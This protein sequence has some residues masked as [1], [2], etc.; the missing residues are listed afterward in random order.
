MTKLFGVDIA[1]ELNAAMGSGLLP[2]TLRKVTAGRRDPAD[3][4]GGSRPRKGDSPARGLIRDYTQAERAQ[5]EVAAADRRIMLL[6]A[7]LPAGIVP[8]P[9]DRITIEGATYRIVD[10]GVRRDAASAT[11]VCR[12]RI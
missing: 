9:G 4:T 2:A 7:S 10:D 11:Y 3:P 12:A 6:G 1:K 8:E 5:G